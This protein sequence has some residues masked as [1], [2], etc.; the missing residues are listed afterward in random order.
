[1]TFKRAHNSALLL[2]IAAY[3][4]LYKN[5]FI[6][7]LYCHRHLTINFNN[8]TM[9]FSSYE[10]KIPANIRRCIQACRWLGAKAN[11]NISD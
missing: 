6:H 4:R 11:E 9:G 8:A 5:D 7:S 3:P 10:C 2:Q 1:M